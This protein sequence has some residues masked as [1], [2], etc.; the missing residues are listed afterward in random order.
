M[1]PD[2]LARLFQQRSQARIIRFDEQAVPG[3]ELS[4][5]DNALWQRFR[6]SRTK[7]EDHDLFTK[8]A[9]VRVDEDGK[10]RPTVCGVLMASNDPCEWL[11]NAYI[12]AVAYSGTSAVPP[13]WFQC[14]P[15]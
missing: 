14:L 5:L 2:Y 6:T 8:L 1:A 11:P 12:Q 7:D 3:A 10:L 13:R 15:T 4:D 9:M